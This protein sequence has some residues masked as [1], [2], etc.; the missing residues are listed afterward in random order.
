MNNFS[1][2]G[3]LPSRHL[4]LMEVL[5]RLGGHPSAELGTDG[6]FRIR[7]RK[8]YLAATAV[9]M[10]TCCHAAVAPSCSQD[11]LL[12]HLSTHRVDRARIGLSRASN[13][14]DCIGVARV[15]IE[16]LEVL[17]GLLTA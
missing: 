4:L 17:L 11:F 9:A 2:E 8:H 14:R 7:V 12:R 15:R 6:S 10:P 16:L 5:L 13:G 3:A 1:G